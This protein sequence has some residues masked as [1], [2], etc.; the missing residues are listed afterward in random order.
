M[1]RVRS[2]RGQAL[3][4]YILLAVLFVAVTVGVT[5][6]FGAAWSAKFSRISAY[7]AGVVGIAP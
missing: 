7:R 1:R 6:L 3:V 5:R 4:E 2:C